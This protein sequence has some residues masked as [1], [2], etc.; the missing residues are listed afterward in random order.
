MDIRA[1]RKDAKRLSRV[2]I[3]ETGTLGV[4]V[5]PCERHILNR[6]IITV[7][8]VIDDVKECVKVK[9]AT[10][11]K[12]KVIRF[13]PE[14]EDVKLLSDK[15]GKPMREISEIAAMRAREVFLNR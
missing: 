11:R 2:V 14:Y 10:D 4:R 7:D 13:K 15:T 5:Y 8:V 1:D 12:G 6:E 3:E 9:V